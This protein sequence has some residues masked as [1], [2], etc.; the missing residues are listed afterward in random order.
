MSA[1]NGT[2]YLV[3][4]APID[5]TYHHQIDFKNPEEQFVFW[6]SKVI[7]ELTS[8]SY[9]RR[10]KRSIHVSIPFDELDGINYLY[11]RAKDNAKFYYAFVTDR[12][13]VNPKSSI[14]FF[15]IDVFQTFMFDFKFKPSYV[16]QAH[17][18][19][20]DANHKP[21]YSRT[22]EGL[23]Y[24]SEYVNEAAFKMK[25]NTTIPHGFYLIYTKSDIV[26]LPI[27]DQANLIYS[28]PPTVI[29]G[30]AI[31]Y[32]LYIIPEFTSPHQ[33]RVF[34]IETSSGVEPIQTIGEFQ[35][36]MSKSALGNNVQQIAYVPYLPIKYEL[37]SATALEKENS[38]VDNVFAFDSETATIEFSQLQFEDNVVLKWLYI[39]SIEFDKIT[40]Q[41]AKMDLF[42]G[43]ESKMP[44]ESMFAAIKAKP[45]TTERDRR[46]E[47]K[48]LCYPYRYN[49]FTD[50]ISAPVLVKNEYVASDK[51]SV[52]GSIGFGFNTPR[53][54]W[55]ENYRKDPEGREASIN[56]LIPYEQPII[57]DAY[58]T[59]L[60][61]N[62]NQISANITNAKA[63]ALLSIGSGIVGGAATGGLRGAAAGAVSSG[64][65]AGVNISNML[66]SENA[67]QAD[68]RAIPDTIS[69]SNDS[70]LAIADDSRYITFYRK[71][72]TCEF[73]E[74][75]AQY[76]HMFGYKVNQLMIPNLRSRVR[77]NYVQ[78]MGANLE[79]SIEN[80]FLLTLKNVFN[81]G[82]TIWHYSSSDF[83]PLDYTFEN[84]EV[85]LT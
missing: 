68:L 58:Y 20:W 69:N 34:G 4:G 48:L 19:R 84:P 16:L 39:K 3:S 42:T 46:F 29:S 18:D 11:Y 76:W 56:Q 47:S 12:Q 65:Q 53:R 52:K 2:I 57:S 64:I 6:G 1:P 77:Y 17:V 28:N 74:Q 36:V 22:D 85:S 59:Y 25:P 44:S 9:V 43:I 24:G 70:T 23:N 26:G 5:M 72:I 75:L 82:V 33:R 38:G 14:I 62:R 55:I 50:W 37:R 35:N 40:K 10:E 67:K 21:I 45:R 81:N 78:T 80:E 41:F 60:L 27:N 71:A 73:E 13:Y 7:K 30:N 63:N 49:I 66:R 8:Y 79:A 15:E 31:P 83:A 32:S 54:F 51:I 61:E